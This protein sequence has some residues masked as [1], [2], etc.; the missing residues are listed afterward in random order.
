[1]WQY[2]LNS[3]I[4]IGRPVP[5]GRDR[6]GCGGLS[7]LCATELPSKQKQERDPF[8]DSMK[9]LAIAPC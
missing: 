4:R 6:D 1:M 9:K 2:L 8:H 7:G 3:L 5:R